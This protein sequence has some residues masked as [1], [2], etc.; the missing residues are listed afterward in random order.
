MSPV[1]LD[2]GPPEMRRPSFQLGRHEAS[3]EWATGTHYISASQTSS[4]LLRMA[5]VTS[6]KEATCR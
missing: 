6:Q 3:I 5:C 2:T 1:K 4:D